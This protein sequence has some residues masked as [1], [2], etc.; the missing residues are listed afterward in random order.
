MSCEFCNSTE[1][2]YL[3][4]FEEHVN[5]P[6]KIDICKSCHTKI[7]WEHEDRMPQNSVIVDGIV[8]MKRRIS[9]SKIS[10]KYKQYRITLPKKFVEYHQTDTFY[11]VQ[12]SSVIFLVPNLT[13]L[14]P[15]LKMIPDIYN[16]VNGGLKN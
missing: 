16:Y 12:V 6:R 2:L 11:V 3:N 4:H 1:K 13:T 5:P 7:H 9:E 8:I 14:F 15:I 10:E